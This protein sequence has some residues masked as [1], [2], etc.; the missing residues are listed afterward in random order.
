[1]AAEIVGIRGA[2][3]ALRH[4]PN[5]RIES[6][7]LFV[8]VRVVLEGRSGIAHVFRFG[9]DSRE[10]LWLG[11]VMFA[12]YW[13]ALNRRVS[14]ADFPSSYLCMSLSGRSYRSCKWTTGSCHSNLN[15]WIINMAKAKDCK[16]EKSSGM[17][18]VPPSLL[19]SLSISPPSPPPFLS[20]SIPCHLQGQVV[21][22][23]QD[24][25]K[26]LSD[27]LTIWKKKIWIANPTSASHGSLRFSR[28]LGLRLERGCVQILL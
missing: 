5:R 4:F 12:W 22:I 15:I 10:F 2:C 18:P 19:P 13:P 16:S 24:S 20:H 3:G 14:S 26:M 28:M 7:Y 21:V 25:L 23:L 8:V 17:L 27:L 9:R 1:M 11:A 6:S